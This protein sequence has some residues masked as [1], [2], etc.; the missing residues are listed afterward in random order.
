MN[1]DPDW[2]G[3]FLL[4]T[5]LQTRQEDDEGN[6][7]RKGRRGQNFVVIFFFWAVRG[8]SEG[9]FLFMQRFKGKDLIRPCKTRQDKKHEDEG[10][11]EQK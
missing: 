3:L 9:F 8:T 11:C 10:K 4:S 7:A 5:I 2:F 1:E 6:R